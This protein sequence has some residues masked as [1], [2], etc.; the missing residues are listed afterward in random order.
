MGIYKQLNS[1]ISSQFPLKRA[2]EK[3]TGRAQ[4]FFF[5]SSVIQPRLNS[6]EPHLLQG[7]PRLIEI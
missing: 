5:F 4:R 7:P 1:V 3:N 2:V 6:R